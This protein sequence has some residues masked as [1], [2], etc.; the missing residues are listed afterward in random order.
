M[1]IG[2]G[3][4]IKIP[5][6]ILICI[7]YIISVWREGKIG[8]DGDIKIPCRILICIVYIISVWR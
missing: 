2:R 7:V 1:E 6:R 8:S 5:C 3:G 4:D